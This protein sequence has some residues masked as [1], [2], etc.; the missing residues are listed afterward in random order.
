MATPPD[1]PST[2]ENEYEVEIISRPVGVR[3]ENSDKILVD[4]VLANGIGAKLG[5]EAGDILIEI[6]GTSIA[7]LQDNEK[8]VELFKETELPFTAKF[9]KSVPIDNE[10]VNENSNSV[11]SGSDERKPDINNDDINNDDVNTDNNMII[12]DDD[13]DDDD[14]DTPEPQPSPVSIQDLT[15]WNIIDVLVWLVTNEKFIKYQEIFWKEKI[16]GTKLANLTQIDLYK[17]GI[18]DKQDCYHLYIAIQKVAGNTVSDDIKALQEADVEDIEDEDN[19]DKK[20]D[21]NTDKKVDDDILNIFDDDKYDYNDNGR[22]IS[23][24]Q[25]LSWKRLCYVIC[26]YS[27]WITKCSQ[28][29]RLSIYKK[30]LQFE[31]ENL[32]IDIN[33]YQID[34]NDM[35]KE[36]N[37]DNIKLLN[38]FNYLKVYYFDNKKINRNYHYIHQNLCKKLK[39]ATKDISGSFLLTRNYRN[40]SDLKDDKMMKEWY[41]VS[42]ESDINDNMIKFINTQQLFDK[43]Y[44][45]FIHGYDI[46]SILTKQEEKIWNNK[47]NHNK[48]NND[49]DDDN[50]NNKD[51]WYRSDALFNIGRIIEA[52]RLNLTTKISGLA[53]LRYKKKNNRFLTNYE[54]QYMTGYRYYYWDYHKNNDKLDYHNPGYSYCDWYIE[55]KYDSLKTELMFNNIHNITLVQWNQLLIKA[56]QYQQTEYVKTSISKKQN[57]NN[58]NGVTVAHIVALLAYSNFDRLTRKFKTTFW[59]KPISETNESLKRRHSNFCHFSRLLRELIEKY[60]ARHYFYDKYEKSFY[61]GINTDTPYRTILSTYSFL[62]FTTSYQNIVCA[63]DNNG[64]VLEVEENDYFFCSPKYINCSI[65]SDYPA[66][67]EYVFIPAEVPNVQL[68]QVRNVYDPRLGYN[69]KSYLDSL[70]II[71]QMVDGWLFFTIDDDEKYND[72]PKKPDTLNQSTSNLKD[73]KKEDLNQNLINL[74]SRL[75]CHELSLYKQTFNSI[76]NIPKYINVL[77]HDFFLSI[78]TLN[79]IW[80][81]WNEDINPNNKYQIGY[82]SIVS[83]IFINSENTF[84]N[85]HLIFTLFPN[86]NEIKI[87]NNTQ[88]KDSKLFLSTDLMDEIYINIKNN[89]DKR[90]KGT[91][92][93]TTKSGNKQKKRHSFHLQKITIQSPRQKQ[94]TITKAISI[95]DSIFEKIKWNVQRGIENDHIVVAKQHS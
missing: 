36:I 76:K 15:E 72:L 71:R 26:K 2:N 89:E 58:N 27:E 14:D 86:L 37:Y 33:K 68:F 54:S 87:I 18:T 63:S 23:I 60:G 51:E 52:K 57:D 79:I 85:L 67:N 11:N 24:K 43:I 12:M 21:D 92:I 66:E 88:Y 61:H 53:K 55:P 81:A 31:N 75:I 1:S 46:G 62:S 39:N 16:D 83:K 84:L 29:Q 10:N 28:I 17:F 13:E 82:G 74:I 4:Q 80:E 91:I 40:R 6:N 48:N 20:I 47:D 34:I 45:Y 19:M 50:N 64:L 5:I 30:R 73:L 94:L 56:K 3:L 93:T 7:D 35:M 22:F 38:D 44:C 70:L 42:A 8:A 78:K 90:R 41:F 95:Y 25:C 59:K 9:H 65:F 77:L 32:L 49:D 69:F